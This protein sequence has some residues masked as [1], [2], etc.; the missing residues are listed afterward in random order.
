MQPFSR[1]KHQ[2]QFVPIPAPRSQH[3]V[4]TVGPTG[5]LLR[6]DARGSSFRGF[7]HPD[8]IVGVTRLQQPVASFVVEL[9][10]FGQ[11][12]EQLNARWKRGHGGG[13]G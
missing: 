3:D 8:A 6:D 5:G 9:D 4:L 11:G 13:H 10:G 2:V 12:Q 7:H 1:L